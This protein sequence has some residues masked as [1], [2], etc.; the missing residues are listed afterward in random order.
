MISDKIIGEVYRQLAE[1]HKN[2][3]M[4]YTGRGSSDLPKIRS[5]RAT[6]AEPKAEVNWQ[7]KSDK[8]FAMAAEK[9]V[10]VV[11]TAGNEKPESTEYTLESVASTPSENGLSVDLKPSTG[12]DTL[13]LLFGNGGGNWALTGAKVGDKVVSRFPA[14]LFASE[15]Y[16]MRCGE[17]LEF[18]IPNDNTYE[19][20][21]KYIIHNSQFLPVFKETENLGFDTEKIVQCTGYYTPGILSGLFVIL[22]LL[23]IM[24][25]GLS[26]I[27]DIRTM[28]KFDDPKGKTITINASD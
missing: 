20:F 13:T 27:M 7:L 11:K 10:K 6:N 2:I 26:F 8:H 19:S 16:A 22:L 25:W 18:T 14:Y 4:I 23:I 24:I 9:I 12:G 5:R 28:D 15:D 21:T 3:V 1:S 17:G